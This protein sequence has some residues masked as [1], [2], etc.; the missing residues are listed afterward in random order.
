MQKLCKVK[1]NASI[2]SFYIIKFYVINHERRFNIKNIRRHRM[3][4]CT[5]NAKC[6]PSSSQSK[7]TSRLVFTD[8]VFYMV[9]KKKHKNLSKN[10]FLHFFKNVVINVLNT[11]MQ[12]IL[13]TRIYNSYSNLQ[14]SCMKKLDYKMQNTATN[15]VDNAYLAFSCKYQ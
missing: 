2:S 5:C 7:V 3:C 6:C 12:A 14:F 15:V 13:I 8:S 11:H 10:D 4:K 9:T 1:W